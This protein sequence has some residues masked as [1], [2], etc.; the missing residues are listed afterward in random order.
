MKKSISLGAAELIVRVQDVGDNTN[1]G[2]GC[3]D[4][5]LIIYDL[6]FAK[7]AYNF[8]SLG[9]INKSHGKKHH[10]YLKRIFS[11]RANRKSGI[12]AE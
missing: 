2:G 4:F 6:K 1:V 12:D 8:E 10:S 5:E 11:T 9:N 3:A 7:K